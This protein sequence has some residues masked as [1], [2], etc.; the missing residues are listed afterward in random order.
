MGAGEPVQLPAVAVSWLPTVAVPVT[1]GGWL[2]SGGWETAGM[3][4]VGL[5][6]AWFVPAVLVAVTSTSIVKPMS[7]VGD[8]VGGVGGAADR[9]AVGAVCVAA[10]A[11][12]R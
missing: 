5:L 3:V 2:L 7:L 6:A 9:A 4:L 1:V 12:G 8:G 10:L 11:T